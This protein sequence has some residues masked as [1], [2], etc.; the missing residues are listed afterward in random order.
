MKERLELGAVRVQRFEGRGG[1]RRVTT[2]SSRPARDDL[3][4]RG[5]LYA[6]MQRRWMAA[7]GT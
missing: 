6:D 5:G 3:A 1:R 4:R 7:A 2:T